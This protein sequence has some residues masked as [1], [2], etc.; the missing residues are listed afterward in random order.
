ML[1]HYIVI[2][3]H[4]T[5]VIVIINRLCSVIISQLYY[6]ELECYYI[7]K[8]ITRTGSAKNAQYHCMGHFFPSYL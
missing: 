5:Y 2:L 6:L 7:T 3:H 8:A 4:T 1:M